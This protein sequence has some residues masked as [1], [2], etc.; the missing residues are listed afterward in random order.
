M[1]QPD[2]SKSEVKL[3]GYMQQKKTLTGWARAISDILGMNTSELDRSVKRL[4]SLDLISK[5]VKTDESGSETHVL[6]LSITDKGLGILVIFDD[7]GPV[8]KNAEIKNLIKDMGYTQKEM[9]IELD[10][11]Y[12]SFQYMLSRELSDVKKTDLIKRINV[13]R[14]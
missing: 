13:L 3:L 11:P 12:Q 6:K 10:Y 14:T 8:R 2:F 4:S 7:Y 9:A 1:G 5:E